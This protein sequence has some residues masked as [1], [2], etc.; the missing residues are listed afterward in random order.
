MD[1][2]DTLIR[3]ATIVDGSGRASYIADLAIRGER[4][5]LLGDAG[6]A[7]ARRE[8]DARGLVLAPGFID[9]H[10]HDDTQVI[11]QPSM[12]PK[13]SQGVTTVIVGNCGISAAP[14]S[15]TGAPPDPMNLL[16]PAS[17]FRYPRFADYRLAVEAARPAVN[18]AALVGHTALRSNHLD[19]LDRPPT[20]LT[21]PPAPPHPRKS[22]P[23]AGNWRTA[24]T[25][26]PW[27]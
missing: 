9:V 15:L 20:P 13:L 17:A 8:L 7:R 25:P 26:A 2:F 14:V 19:R 5:A 11:R 24:W 3:Q 23:C 18:V 21:A 12:L 6:Q 27:A 16:G 10:T 1:T 22:Q 4:I